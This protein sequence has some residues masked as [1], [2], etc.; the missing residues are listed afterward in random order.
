MAE[1]LIIE[2]DEALV[3][4]LVEG[5]TDSGIQTRSM[6]V[7]DSP[8]RMDPGEASAIVL[9]PSLEV[10]TALTLAEA[11]IATDRAP[12]VVMLAVKFDSD[13]FRRA[14][15][16]G[17]SDVLPASEVE[18][19]DVVESVRTALGQRAAGV[20][21]GLAAE[22]TG[23]VVMVHSTKGGVGKTM[24]ASNL[25]VALADAGVATALVDLDLIS[26]DVGLS[27]K[28]EPRRTI[29]DAAQMFDKLDSDLM[30]SLLV[31]HD[32]GL[33][34]LLAPTSVDEAGAVTMPRVSAIID[35]LKSMFQVVVLDT[36]SN[37]DD[38]VLTAVDK[39]DV[40]LPLA[41]MDVASIKSARLS[42]QRLRDLGYS[43]GSVRLVM[44]RADSKVW[45]DPVD[46]ERSVGT[47]IHARIPS[48][49]LVPRSLN[50]GV[51]VVKDAPRS[52][53]AR[54]ITAMA[55]ELASESEVRGWR[56]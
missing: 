17:L 22:K 12:G 44:N 18:V 2:S 31:S 24:L 6:A 32:S 23:L 46:V 41:T 10:D 30:K 13:V 20:D 37:L 27:L 54:S 49:R 53:V 38:L 3:E 14:L 28:L 50:R 5:F 55:R 51:P 8:E 26:G 21:A 43:N 39:S 56:S 40:I 47:S 4:K 1:V 11:A 9:G 52:A 15:R 36:G 34:V 42:V 7:P 45:L 35:L 29:A 33:S 16:A 25:A 19:S 48:D